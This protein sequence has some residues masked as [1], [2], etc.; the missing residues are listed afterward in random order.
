MANRVMV[1]PLLDPLEVQLR[2]ISKAHLLPLLLVVFRATMD[3]RAIQAMAVLLA[4]ILLYQAWVLRQGL[5]VVLAVSV[6]LLDLGLS[7]RVITEMARR[8]AHLHL[9]HLEMHPRLR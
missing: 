1:L 6:L 9:P 2:G 8:A 4:G 3:I 5:V 7:S